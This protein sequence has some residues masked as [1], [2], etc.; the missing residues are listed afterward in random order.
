MSAYRARAVVQL[1]DACPQLPDAILDM[2]LAFLVDANRNYHAYAAGPYLLPEFSFLY[3]ERRA[4]TK[5]LRLRDSKVAKIEDKVL[6][7]N[8]LPELI[9]K[10]L[11]MS[12]P[13]LVG[14]NEQTLLDETVRKSKEILPDQMQLNPAF[15]ALISKE[16][17]DLALTLGHPTKVVAK[18]H[19]LVIYKDGDFFKTHIDSPHG[20]TEPMI[21]TAS[22]QLHTPPSFFESGGDLV[23]GKEKIRRTRRNEIGLT[24]FYHDEPHSVTRLSYGS[25]ISL[26]FDVLDTG[27]PHPE[28][29]KASAGAAFS[30]VLAMGFN[31]VAIKSSHIYIT[32]APLVREQLKGSDKVFCEAAE[33]N[34]AKRIDICTVYENEGNLF[35][36]ELLNVIKLDSSFSSLYMPYEPEYDDEGDCY[37]CGCGEDEGDFGE[38]D[39]EGDEEE[40]DQEEDEEEEQKEE[41]EA[42]REEDDVLEDLGDE[43][44][45]R[46]AMKRP[47]LNLHVINQPPASD[48]MRSPW[49]EYNYEASPRYDDE[50]DFKALKDDYRLGDTLF[51]A[52]V[53]PRQLEYKSMSDV[54]LGNQGFEGKLYSNLAIIA[55]F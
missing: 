16:I 21:F 3:N 14:K 24:L 30:N 38:G 13:S 48:K 17:Q 9:E 6:T 31:R 46:L 10:L 32:R 26:V 18:L 40:G 25:R 37:G 11:S 7:T 22:V 53:A 54:H 52:T 27:I 50:G 44:L 15:F 55:Y 41:Q 36:S 5:F 29:Q 45:K 35:R 2:T 1:R 19:K 43:F 49:S 28:A 39:E 4:A 51:L 33:A 42:K 23:I 12:K 34:G 8:V 20:N 47:E